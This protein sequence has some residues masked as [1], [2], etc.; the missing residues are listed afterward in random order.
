ML[1]T[2][3]SDEELEE[4]MVEL[5]ELSDDPVVRSLLA[6]YVKRSPKYEIPDKPLS[7]DMVYY[8]ISNELKLDGN[9]ALNLASFVTTEMDDYTDRLFMENAGKN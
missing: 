2:V 7:P 8:M 5:E 9:P 6:F 1:S 3:L 4:I